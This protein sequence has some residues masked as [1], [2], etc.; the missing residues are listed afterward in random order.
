MNVEKEKLPDLLGND[1]LLVI[2]G[3]AVGERS[4]K[5]GLYYAGRGNNFW[6][7]LHDVG[8]TRER[9]PLESKDYEKLLTYGIGLTDIIKGK[10]GSD[11]NHFPEDFKCEDLRQKILK[12]RPKILCFNGKR[13]AKVFL[14][15]KH[16][17]Y[18]Y[19]KETI[20][21]TL[22]FVAPSTSGAARGYWDQTSWEKLSEEV[23]KYR[24]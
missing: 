10:A 20:G 21:S 12:F 2:C 16:V 22:L 14:G 17:E 13:A 11:D 15:K 7:V 9:K 4:A 19:Q 24:S 8:L 1:L 6:E 23:H 3:T 5:T 18:G